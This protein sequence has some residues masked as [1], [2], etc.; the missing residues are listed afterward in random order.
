MSLAS[1]FQYLIFLIVV[2]ALVKPAGKYLVR[3]FHGERTWL[4]HLM[5]P[6]ERMVYWVCRVDPQREMSWQEYALAFVLF[7]GVGTLVLYAILRMQSFLPGGPAADALTTPITPDLAMNTAISFVTTTTWQA[8]AG[9]N[10]MKYW[11]QLIGLAAQNFFAGAAGLAIGIAFIRGFARRESA[12]IGSFWFDLVRSILWVLLPLSFIGSLLL[13]WQGVPMTFGPYARVLCRDAGTQIIAKGPVAALELIKNLGTNGGGFFNANGA[14]P[15]EG[16]TPLANWIGMLAIAVLPTSLTYT[17]G[18]MVGRPRAGWMLYAAMAFLFLTGLV[19]CDTGERQGI[20][21]VT[22]LGVTAPNM[23]G[24][25]TRFGIP[26]S[27]LTAVVS[28]DGATGSTNAQPDSLTPI[29]LTVPLCN[30]LLGEIIFGGL[31]TGLYSMVMVAL[32][33]LFLAGLMIGRSPEYLGKKLGPG[34]TT[35]VA[36][37]ALTTPLAILLPLAITVLTPAGLAGLG[38]KDGPHGFTEIFFAYASCCANNGQSMAGLNAASPFY[39]LMTAGV[40]MVGR[41][42]LSIPALALA[43]RLALQGRRAQHVGTLPSDSVWFV[44]VAVVAAI[45]LVLLTFLPAL[46][47]GPM[48]EQ[49]KMRA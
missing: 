33:G 35:L 31:G 17:F 15:F 16:P 39:N 46:A 22:A 45:L 42:G 5:I 9:E 32:V 1:I 27:V 37:F 23:E 18:H 41:F 11:T 30:M 2:T 28:S 43:G 25:E 4:D 3:V 14:H 13:I 48:I 40:M 49:L 29:G 21:S 44:V 47:M 7:S 20:P 38:A 10:T 34:E 24:K 19:F 8:Y 6:V 26:Q 36:V 12:A